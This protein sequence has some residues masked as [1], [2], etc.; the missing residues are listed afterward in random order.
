LKTPLTSN[1]SELLLFCEV[2]WLAKGKVLER[3][4]SLKDEV[5]EFLEKNNELPDEC[6]LLRD[7]NW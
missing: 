2:R 7:K 3:F 5:I 4:W 1:N 6:E